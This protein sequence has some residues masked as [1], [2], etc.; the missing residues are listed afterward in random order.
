G[1]YWEWVDEDDNLRTY[2]EIPE[3]MTDGEWSQE[4]TP[5]FGLALPAYFRLDD[6]LNFDNADKA[7]WQI[8]ETEEKLEPY[9]HYVFPDSALTV[10]ERKKANKILR[11]VSE[12]VEEWEAKF[13]SGNA[14]L[15][16]WDDYV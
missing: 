7:K 14:S 13:I 1:G 6:Q 11:D 4:F 8:K 10:D 3:G 2:T 12:Y 15:S 5:G 9:G 16:E